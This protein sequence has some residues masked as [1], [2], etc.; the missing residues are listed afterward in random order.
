MEQRVFKNY[1]VA[2]REAKGTPI[3]KVGKFY[4]IGIA[5][6]DEI[7]IVENGSYKGIVTAGHLNRLGNANWAESRYG[8][9][10]AMGQIDW[11]K[12]L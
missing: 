3:V 11:K 4:V 8:K 9:D 1:T 10:Y 7:A 5:K 6:L 12:N 2:K